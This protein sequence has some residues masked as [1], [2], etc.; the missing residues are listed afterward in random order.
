M[1]LTPVN[2]GTFDNDPTA[3]KIRLAFAKVNEMFTEIYGKVP[4]ELTGEQGKI[5]VVKAT[6][7]GFE[8]V[9][10]SGG[11]DMLSSNNLSDLTNIANARL[12]L[13][14][15]TAA[16]TDSTEYATPAQ[17]AKADS[18]LQSIVAGTGA[19]VDATDP[20]NPIISIAEGNDYTVSGVV[21]YANDRIRLTLFSTG[22][23]DIPFI[24]KPIIDGF[25]IDKG[26]GNINFTA[27]EVGDFG[28]GWDGTRFVAFRVDGLPY[29]T[30]GNRAYALNSEIL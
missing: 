26:S 23:V 28:S 22:T 21:D 13:G 17:G 19:S 9:S 6:E 25:T 29:T 3:E 4:L 1:S 8:L 18:A 16:T 7:D 2:N 11:G 14:L 20:L 27:I 30:E 10:L 24:A 5:L 12:E 15:G